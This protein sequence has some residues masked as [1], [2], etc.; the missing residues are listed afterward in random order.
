MF[1][2]HTD[3]TH[4]SQK[5]TFLAKKGGSVEG[6]NCVLNL[7]NPSIVGH[8]NGRGPNINLAMK[9]ITAYLNSRKEYQKLQ[10]PL[11]FWRKK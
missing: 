6:Y 10:S 7:A 9:A 4:S 3:D 8:T 5:L 11:V 2:V 1:V